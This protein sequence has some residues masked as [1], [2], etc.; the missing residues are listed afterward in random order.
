VREVLE[1]EALLRRIELVYSVLLLVLTGGA[2]IWFSWKTAL[3]VLL[4][5][6]IVIVSFQV[7]KWQLRRALQIPGRIPS[8]AAV[9]ISYYLRFLATLVVVFLVLYLGWATPLPFLVGLSVV[10]LSIVLVGVI[11]YLMMKKGES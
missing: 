4:G 2:V 9:F 7:L 1:S 8:K 10:V 6:G 11:E 3:S 5:G